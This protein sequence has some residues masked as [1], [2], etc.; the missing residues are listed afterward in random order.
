MTTFVF[1]IQVIVGSI[2]IPLMIAAA[3]RNYKIA[4]RNIKLSQEVAMAAI[5]KAEEQELEKAIARTDVDSV[6]V[7]FSD[8]EKHSII[9]N[10][11]TML[12]MTVH[13]ANNG[14]FKMLAI[15]PRHN[16]CYII[17]VEVNA[18]ADNKHPAYPL[19]CAE[20]IKR[21]AGEIEVEF[22]NQS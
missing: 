3:H 13:V 8:I 7:H 10:S 4:Q 6:Q 21:Y 12:S 18:F 2:L 14:T 9:R 16:T 20:V 17:D 11:R 5:A 1:I 15:I 19:V 22:R